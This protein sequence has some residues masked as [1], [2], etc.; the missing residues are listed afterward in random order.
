MK[1]VNIKKIDESTINKNSY[2]KQNYVRRSE[3]KAAYDKVIIAT[4]ADADG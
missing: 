1:S 3:K 2:K 4:D